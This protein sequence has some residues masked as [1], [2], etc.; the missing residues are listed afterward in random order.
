MLP[1]LFAFAAVFSMALSLAS[2]FWTGCVDQPSVENEM[3]DGGKTAETEEEEIPHFSSVYDVKRALLAA[4]ELEYSRICYEKQELEEYDDFLDQMYDAMKEA[5]FTIED[6][7]QLYREM[8]KRKKTLLP[9]KRDI[10]TVYLT[11]DEVTGGYSSCAMLLVPGKDDKFPLLSSH[12]CEIR[13]RGNSTAGAPKQPYK[14]R[15]PEKVSLCGMDKGKTWVLLANMFDKTL[16]RN[17]LAFDLAAAFQCPYTSQSVFVEVY[18]N[19]SYL[20]NYVLCEPVTDGRKRVNLDVEEFDFL[21]ELDMN[22]NDG[23]YYVA[24]RVG[25]RMKV[26]KPENMTDQQKEYLLQFLNDAEDALLTHDMTQYEMYFD[27]SSFVN[28]YLFSELTK[29]IDGY[30]FST[31]YFIK[32]GK[33]YAG[34]MWDSDLSM[35]N[36]SGVVY[37][38]K[39]WIYRNINGYGDGSGDSARGLWADNY[40]FGALLKDPAFV[41]LAKERYEELQ[42]VITGVYEGEDCLIDQYLAQ[43][44][45]SF[46]ANYEAW[47]SYGCPYYAIYSP[48]EREDF[49]SYEEETEAL[50]DWLSRRNEFL[51]E[52]LCG[53]TP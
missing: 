5:D 36:V 42:P 8:N 18:L 3:T 26:E 52:N 1:K 20:G 47:E 41:A 28:F 19:D 31:R 48:Y 33:L 40:W 27:I 30:D 34:P 46:A 24:P 13:I 49:G 16:M 17:K 6:G 35:G 44:G 45:A 25:Q 9:Q 37:E 51:K 53:M 10:A 12:D 22:R 7:E 38:E 43:Y 21:L 11:A 50:K 32:D 4:E 23:S 39:Y 29:N 14:L 15:F 2:V